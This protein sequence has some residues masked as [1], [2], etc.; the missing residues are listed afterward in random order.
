SA[1]DGFSENAWLKIN[2]RLPPSIT[3][4]QVSEQLEAS[5]AD[6]SL[7]LGESIAAYRAEKNTPIVRGFLAAVR[8]EG[9]E[10]AFTLKTGTSD[11]NLVAP[12]W[13][14]PAV[15]YGPGDSS[16]DHTPQEHI[17][18]I[19]YQKSIRVLVRVL[20]QVESLFTG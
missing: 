2:L 17:S 11:M 18:L 4:G 8:G 5:K 1:T 12:V 20:E 15:A 6:G 9:G 13:Q 19:E 14:C 10:P 7:Q 16:L 3:V